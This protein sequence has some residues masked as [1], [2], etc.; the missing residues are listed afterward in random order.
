VSKVT[1]NVLE[2]LKK[3]AMDRNQLLEI[4]IDGLRAALS[5]T[6]EVITCSMSKKAKENALL[7][8]GH[9]DRV[10]ML[11]EVRFFNET[12]YFFSKTKNYCIYFTT[13]V[14][15]YYFF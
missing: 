5:R 4:S 3:E 14:S 13:C 11:G 7:S 8:G 9:I 2:I 10:V 12:Q 15:I 6:I 1:T